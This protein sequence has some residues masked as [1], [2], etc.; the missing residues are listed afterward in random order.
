MYLFNRITVNPQLPKRI[1]KLSKISNNLWWSWNTEFLRLFRKIDNDLWEKCGKN[2]VK[3][4]KQVSQDRLEAV[5]KDLIFLHEYDKC[6]ENFEDYMNSKDTWFA[7]KYPDNKDDLIAYFSAEYGLD[8]TIPIYSGGLGILSGDHLKSASDLGIPL[9][10]VGLLYK[11][12][13][14]H[15]KINGNGEQETEYHDIDL[16]DLPINPVKNENGDDLIIYLKFPK[17]RI[18][19]KVWQINVGRV[20]LYLLD[21][22]IE[23]NNP[24]DRDVTLRLYGG[25]QEMRIRQEI[26]LG[27][28][29]VNLLTRA[30]KLEP[31]VYHMNEGHSSFLIL[32]LIKN[33]IKEKQVSFDVA[34]DIVS[35]QTVFTTHT[36]V[37]AGNDIFPISL[38][39]K[40]FK[41]FWPRLTISREE[42]LKLGMKP[43]EEL[44]N[45]FNMGILALKVA[46][47]KNG[48]SKLHGAV[49][50]ELFADVWPE[51]AANESPIDYVTNGIHT[52]SWLAPSLK[53]LYNKYLIPYWQDKIQYDYVWEK[54][55]NI[56]DDK[57]WNVHQA[58][59]EKLLSIV[60]DNVTERL[61]RSGYNYEDINAIT[62]K[63]NPNALTIGFARRFATYKRATLIFKDLE[64]ITQILNNADR[65]VQLIFAGKAHPADK[66]GQDLIKFIHDVSMMPQFKGKIF[67]LENYNIAMSRYLISGVDVWLNNPRRPMEASGTSGQKASV[68]GVVN[69]S[70]LDGW[71]AEGYNQKNG[72][73]IGF[74]SDYESYEAQ[75]VTDS[76]NIYETLEQKIIPAYYN[77]D[78]NGISKEWMDYMKESIVSTGGKYSTSRMLS[79][80]TSKFY[81]P[82]CNLHNKYYKD[83][84]DV[85]QFNTWKTDMYRNWKDI[86]ITQKEDNLNNISIDAGNCISV[87]C[88]V[89]LPNIKP[90]FVSVECY[91]G[92]ILENGVVED[93][94][95]IPMQQ[96]KSKSKNAETENSKIF[97]YETKI[98]LK[99]GG[100]YGYTFRVMPKND[101]LL[102]SANM[103][104]VKWITQ[105]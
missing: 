68:N 50:R 59:K 26:V 64:R 82:L 84:S 105:E 33:V 8:E 90:E 5:S 15:Q 29:G 76:Q 40:Y 41:D 69:F 48:V 71:W 49:S 17:R 21:S 67:L 63:I 98:E 18:Y 95:I 1:E 35:S 16:H 102:D 6:V 73:R 58:R 22:D 97:E 51:I 25:D 99:T 14:F 79:D 23:K 80:Y 19:L 11:Y 53:Q 46:G 3:F 43:C 77:K 104:L 57:L 74:N 87:K 2:P 81:I 86:K 65:P 47:K 39:E 34:R 27:M 60:K 100:N 32:E 10:A 61:R 52:C 12:G 54:V 36:P 85:T 24:E 103:N 28:G 62:S 89:E 9:V 38:V 88:Q 83:L 42:F 30:L 91:Y 37:P 13:Y 93:I 4:L 56:P 20:K 7:N 72:W 45:G 101:M 92:K 78:K 31:T 70:V 75:D 55:R 44:E 96:V 66:Q 94:S